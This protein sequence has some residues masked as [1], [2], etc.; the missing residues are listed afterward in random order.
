MK[1][2]LLLLVLCMLWGGVPV[3]GGSY[4]IQLKNG[5][6][7]PTRTYWE[8]GDEIVFQIYGGLVGIPKNF[9][10]SIRET[11]SP[12]DTRGPDPNPFVSQTRPPL[13]AR[14]GSDPIVV[15]DQPPADSKPVDFTPYQKK[16]QELVQQL[17]EARTRYLEALG[18]RDA[19]RQEQARQE[20]VGLGK[21]FYD[22]GDE[23]KGKNKGQL[24]PWWRDWER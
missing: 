1:K 16:Q 4:R 5:G 7:I 15:Q 3:Q 18:I 11:A 23:V 22:L 24:P 9:I 20:M 10:A 21:R 2:C 13:A 19:G 12:P 14:Q 6:E 17:D 8:S